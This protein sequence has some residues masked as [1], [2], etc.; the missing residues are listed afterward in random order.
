[1]KEHFAVIEAALASPA[2]QRDNPAAVATSA[3]LRAA[4]KLMQASLPENDDD[5]REY[6]ET[7]VIAQEKAW[8]VKGVDGGAMTKWE[9]VMFERA[10]ARASA[11]N[12][13]VL[14]RLSEEWSEKHE[15]LK[16]VALRTV[17][18]VKSCPADLPEAIE[19]LETE[20][21]KL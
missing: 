12:W 1:M 10:A 21:R 9:M 8:F 17:T 15:R 18:A 3:A 11:S 7:A 20:A 6:C 13:G 16:S 19:A 5:E 4:L 14:R 2:M